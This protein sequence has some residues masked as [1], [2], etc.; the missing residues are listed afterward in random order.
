MAKRGKASDA[1]TSPHL[2]LPHPIPL[3]SISSHSYLLHPI[4]PYSTH[5]ISPCH[6]TSHLISS[7]LTSSHPIPSHRIS[8]HLTL[9]CLTLSCLTPS[10]LTPSHV[11]PSHPIPFQPT[12][13]HLLQA[14][15]P[16]TPGRAPLAAADPLV[17]EV[18]WSIFLSR[19]CVSENRNLISKIRRRFIMEFVNF[20]RELYSQFLQTTQGEVIFSKTLEIF[21][22]YFYI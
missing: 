6:T 5:P 1:V 14:S 4:L 21:K 10:R 20:R 16:A 8:P 22:K 3:H 2:I 17:V 7:H 12:P 11:I 9:S 13:S 15:M 19:M 18:L